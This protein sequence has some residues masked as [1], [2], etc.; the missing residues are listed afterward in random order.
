MP[1]QRR[2]IQ[3]ATVAID[4]ETGELLV[5]TG[6]SVEPKRAII[7]V[8]SDIA[9]GH[10][11]VAAVD[12]K[13]ICVLGICLLAEEAVDVT[14]YSGPADTG[15]PLTGPIPIGDRGGFVLPASLIPW[16]ETETGESLTLHLSA[17]W[18]CGGWILYAEQ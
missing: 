3:S 1:N 10:E 2:W 16:F 18:R 11:I 9:V 12:G 13:R 15:V 7:N 5:R 4:D 6:G 14:F 8:A 17:N